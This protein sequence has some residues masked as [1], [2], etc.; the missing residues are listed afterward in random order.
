MVPQAAPS[1]AGRPPRSRSP[2]MSYAD[3]AALDPNDTII[4]DTPMKPLKSGRS[5]KVLFD[6]APPNNDARPAKI[7]SRKTA[8]SP[9]PSLRGMKRDRSRALTPSSDEDGDWDARPKLK[10]LEASAALSAKPSRPPKTRVVN[11]KLGVPKA[12]VPARDDLWSDVKPSM[13]K[14]P[15][16][17]HRTQSVSSSRPSRPANKR[18]LSKDFDDVIDDGARDGSTLLDLPLI[19]PS[20]PPESSTSG[21]GKG[22]SAPFGRKKPK[23]LQGSGDAESEEEE[24]EI[25]VREVDPRA[26]S[27]AVEHGGDADS[28]WETQWRA[29]RNPGSEPAALLDEPS[30]EFGKFEVDLPEDLQRILAISPGGR[31]KNSGEKV[32]K[33]LLYESRETHYDASKGG[34]IWDVGE[35]SDHGEGTEDWEGEPVPWEVGEL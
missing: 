6:D 17:L 20:P 18:A 2:E 29:H 35:E 9:P 15:P 7:L 8:D 16:P 4:A 26:H 28:D 34:E 5:F 30:H 24:V 10:S 31:A 13:S 33:S 19:P 14:P 22:K 3:D 32:V 11:G 21:K 1:F 27:T 25:Q 12:L 23:F